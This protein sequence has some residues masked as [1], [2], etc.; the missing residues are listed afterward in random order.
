MKSKS[1][2]SKVLIVK[3]MIITTCIIAGLTGYT[4]CVAQSIV[5]KWNV[6]SVKTYYTEEGAKSHGKQFR[7]TVIKNSTAEYKSDHTVTTSGNNGNSVNGTW[8]LTGDQLKETGLLFTVSFN[9]NNMV[10]T[11]NIPPNKVIS[12]VE[13]TY[14]KM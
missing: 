7:E 1:S 8:S 12:K 6:I 14:T 13:F 2:N 5:G 10:K 4:K 11:Q 3:T 9:G